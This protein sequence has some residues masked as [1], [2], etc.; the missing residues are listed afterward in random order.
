MDIAL[1]TPSYNQ[2]CFLRRTIESVLSQQD[3]AVEHVIVDACSTDDTLSVLRSYPGLRW[4]SEP[5]S[6][7]ANAINKGFGMTEAR[8]LGWL[9]S[10]DYLEPGSLHSVVEAFV[11]HPE[12]DLVYGDVQF[13]DLH[14]RHL[15]TVSGETLTPWGLRRN[16]D[17]I[18]Q[19]GMFFR[20]SLWER[21][22][23]LRE[24]LHLVFD[25]DFFL[26]AV[27]EKP[28]HHIPRVLSCYRHY[29]TTKST[30]LQSKQALEL[31]Q[32]A[33]RHR[34]MSVPLLW[35]VLLRYFLFE[36]AVIG[37]RRKMRELL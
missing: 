5:D 24:D 33:V 22:G 17:L 35:K 10:D 4:V 13:V 9:N 31:F 21:L 7:Q 1:I 37:L 28:F 25:Y 3:V 34:T 18:R 27:L 30:S 15:S 6:G 14:G 23:G 20:R 36:K 19:P 32:V 29:K 16:P 11:S 2:G 8:I 12:T 26:R